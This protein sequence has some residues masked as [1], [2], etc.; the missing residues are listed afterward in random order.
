MRTGDQHRVGEREARGD[1]AD[2]L[3]LCF[4]Q[5]T[6]DPGLQERSFE[7]TDHDPRGALARLG[8]VLVRCTIALSESCAMQGARLRQQHPRHQGSR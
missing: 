1:D 2:G 5:P 8:A 4:E 6:D 7:P 3:R